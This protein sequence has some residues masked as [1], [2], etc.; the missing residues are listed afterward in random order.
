MLSLSH[1]R[2]HK[3]NSTRKRN[4]T[5]MRTK[6]AGADNMG[7]DLTRRTPRNV[8]TQH[9][10]TQPLL[11]PLTRDNE[12]PRQQRPL[13]VLRQSRLELQINAAT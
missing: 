5:G 7:I 8:Q 6:Q 4:H 13:N 2:Y 10:K 11:V 9:N 12:A 3:H 1:H